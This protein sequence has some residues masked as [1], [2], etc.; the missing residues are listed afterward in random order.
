MPAT[1]AEYLMLTQDAYNDGYVVVRSSY[2]N[3]LA[4]LRELGLERFTGVSAGAVSSLKV[5]YE[6]WWR[7]SGSPVMT[8]TP[9]DSAEFARNMSY[10][11]S[12]DDNMMVTVTD[13]GQISS[14]LQ[15]CFN[16]GCP[17]QDP[18][19]VV[20]Y[21]DQGNYGGAAQIR[22]ED[23]PQ[24]VIDSFPEWVR[25]EKYPAYTLETVEYDSVA[26]IGGADGPTEIY[27]TK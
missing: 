16:L 23:L 26:I 3:T 4:V 19:S 13:R 5:Y 21:D 15:H 7:S 22:F 17:D 11:Y 8:I 2:T 18:V 24:Q 14:I 9:Q 25:Q 12:E 27:V 20:F 6:I 10:A 1:P